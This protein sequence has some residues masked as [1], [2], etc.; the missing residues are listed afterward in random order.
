MRCIRSFDTTFAFVF[1]GRRYRKNLILIEEGKLKHTCIIKITIFSNFS[2]IEN[3]W[4]PTWPSFSN[5]RFR[6]QDW[7]FE[8]NQCV[9]IW[10]FCK[11]HILNPLE[12]PGVAAPPL[13]TPSIFF[14]FFF[15]CIKKLN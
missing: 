15:F 3:S 4:L 5:P 8:Q 1:W 2:C 11:T 7:P 9:P 12:W 6:P 10:I 14:F 13:A